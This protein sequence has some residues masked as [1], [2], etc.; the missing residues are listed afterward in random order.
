MDPEKLSNMN[1]VS[2]SEMDTAVQDL[3]I[4][5]VDPTIVMERAR[6]FNA[7]KGEL[8]TVQ[9]RYNEILEQLSEASKIQVQS[10]Q[11]ASLPHPF[12]L[13]SIPAL[14]RYYHLQKQAA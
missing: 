12:T 9:A 6:A 11:R 5:G 3:G 10:N 13:E 1:S 7:V 14:T 4:L 8:A 2:K